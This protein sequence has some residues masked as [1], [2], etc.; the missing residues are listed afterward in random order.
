[1]SL[2]VQKFGGTSVAD[3]DRLRHVAKIITDTYAKG[4]RV[5]AVLSAQGDTTDELIEKAKE[6]NPNPSPREMDML[7]ST[8]E[9][10]SVSL[11]AMA[12]EAMG[13]PVVSLTGWQSGILTNT[14][15][16]NA[17][18]KR[19]DTER[20]E[21]ELDRRRIV[22]VTGFQGI[23][24]LGDITTLGRGGSDTS[25]VALAAAL[26]A[27]LCQIYTDV[28]GVYTADPREVKGARKLDEITYNEMLDLATLGAQVLHNRSVE[29]AKKYN[30]KLEV[31]SSFTGHPGTKIKEVAKGVEKSYISSVAK[32]KNIARIALL[33]VPD[34]TGTSFKVFSLLAA[35]NIN[36]DIILQGIGQAERKDICFTVAEG[37]LERAAGLLKDHQESIG[38][39]AME[40]NADVAKVSV[41]GAGM[42]GSPGVAAKLFE[43]LYD[44]GININ[45][46]S[47]SEIKI[48]VLVD[49][50]DAAKAVQVIH[51][52]FF[53]M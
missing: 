21:A 20:V 38:F 41:V 51:D 12:I 3:A 36:V 35:N 13:Y 19:L 40:T 11:C 6:I 22:I 43:A 46:I 7:L 1:M 15:S 37:D 47:T 39:R 29:M 25:A 33:G 50:K 34:E 5:V 45:M 9:Q 24:R 28:D 53:A 16:M 23:N 32:D 17:R 26:H 4:H 2:I 44:A 14:V 8:G 52:K 18:I 31:L 10:I 27:D 30:V 42:I 49:R 48:S